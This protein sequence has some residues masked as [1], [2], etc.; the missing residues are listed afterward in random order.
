MNQSLYILLLVSVGLL[1]MTKDN[2]KKHFAGKWKYSDMPAEKM[3]VERTKNKQLEYIEDGKYYYEFEI[4][5]VNS[6]KYQAIY[7][8]TNSP[9][10]ANTA[11]GEATT[12]EIL[13]ITRDKMKYHTKFGD[14]EETAEMT[15][16]D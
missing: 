13:E 1:S 16:I 4:K 14:V 15:R 2:C 9:Y 7:K 12:I 5:W 8:G 10:P 3:Y 11:I 6:C